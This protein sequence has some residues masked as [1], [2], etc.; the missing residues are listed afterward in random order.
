MSYNET[1]KSRFDDIIKDGP[2]IYTA[3]LEI[4]DNMIDW[5]K[6]DTISI[7]YIKNCPEKS[8]PLIILKDNGP[9]GFNTEESIHRLFQLGK[10]NGDVTEKTI[11]KYGKG[12]YK[13]IISISDIFEL[14]TFIN[15]NEYNYG[16]NFRLMEENNSWDPTGEWKVKKNKKEKGSIFKLYPS[17]H[18][19]ISDTF[20]LKNLKRHII[21]GYHNSDKKISFLFQNGKEKQKID[22]IREI[23]PYME[24]SKKVMYYIYLDNRDDDI[25]FI[26]EKS[27]R[28]N[29]G[30]LAIITSY[31]L[32]DL[33]TKNELLGSGNTSITTPGVDFYRNK[34]MC[35]TRY[36]IAKIRNIGS[37]LQKGQM[38]GKRCHITFEFSDIK[39]SEDKSMDDYIGV[40]TVKDIYEEDDIM[41]ESLIEILEKIAEECSEMYE[42][43]VNEKKES[44]FNYLNEINNYCNTITKEQLLSHNDLEKY[45][46]EIEYFLEFKLFYYN[47]SLDKIEFAK[48]KS[49]VLELKKKG[50]K[51]VRSNSNSY[52]MAESIYNKISNKI[53]ESEN[54]KQCEKH[55]ENVMKEKNITKQEA[56]DFI[57]EE[58]RKQKEIQKKEREEKERLEKEEKE[59]LEKE[60]LEKERLEEEEE[61]RKQEEKDRLK[62]EKLEKIRLEKEKAKLEEENR[63]KEIR[64]STL[65]KTYYVKLQKIREEETKMSNDNLELFTLVSQDLN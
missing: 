32:K 46:E 65:Y 8:R 43:Y 45:K 56:I 29:Q 16:T 55:I 57:R 44:I 15:E 30:P 62:Q 51:P 34:R 23:S 20:N 25:Q 54:I 9:N 37:L 19:G 4:I 14:T 35:N 49:D 3:L 50:E 13:G 53:A 26:C 33:I 61:K 63:L 1:V 38:R 52:T 17:F 31:I 41:D 24:Y 22:D 12:G 60:R 10:T 11:G 39:I 28:E 18:S 21:R 47:E 58:I 2:N 7:Q 5:G 40:T 36:P 48:S 64:S 6:A 59:R 42:K 27:I